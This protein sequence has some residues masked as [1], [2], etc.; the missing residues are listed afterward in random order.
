[1]SISVWR[2]DVCSSDLVALAE[3]QAE[4][5]GMLDL[6]VDVFQADL[7]GFRAHRIVL[8]AHPTVALQ[9]RNAHWPHPLIFR[10]KTTKA[11]HAQLGRE[12][13]RE[14]VGQSVWIS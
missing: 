6:P 13:C 1:M 4:A 7:L 8:R 11:R 14:R 10:T 2:S 9:I 3:V 12:T 5:F